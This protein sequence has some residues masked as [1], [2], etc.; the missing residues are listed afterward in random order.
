VAV[1]ELPPEEPPELDV[2]YYEAEPSPLL[3]L[4]LAELVAVILL[5]ILVPAT[6]MT[7]WWLRR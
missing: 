4:R 5:M 7:R 6:L 1:A 2:G 3:P